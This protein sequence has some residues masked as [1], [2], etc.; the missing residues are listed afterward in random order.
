MSLRDMLSFFKPFSAI[1]LSE[2]NGKICGA[3]VCRKKGSVFVK[4]T[5]TICLEEDKR[6]VKRL[7][8]T[9]AFLATGLE[10][11]DVLTRS[12]HLPS[13]K[14]KDIDAALS[15][16]AE[17]ILPYPVEEAVLTRV[18]VNQ[19]AEDMDLTLLSARKD[20]VK[21]HLENWQ[22][23]KIEPETT[24]CIQGALSRIGILYPV[25]E[26]PLFVLHLGDK[27]STCIL[28]KEGKLIASYTSHI[29]LNALYQA[30]E[31][32]LS[33]LALDEVDFSALSSDQNPRLCEGL[34]HL[35]TALT[36]MIYA[37][38]GFILTGE[39]VR[40]NSFDLTLEQ[41]LHLPL[42]RFEGRAFGIEAR[43]FQQYA[44]PIGLAIEGL[45][46]T[47]ESLN[48]RQQELSYPHPWKRLKIPV[49]L[50][51]SL[52]LLLSAAAYFFGQLYLEHKESQIKQQYVELLSSMGKSY[53]NFEEAFLAKNPARNDKFNGEI[54]NVIQ[55]DKKD[56]FERLEF[57]QKDLQATPDSFPLFANIPK[58]SDVLAWLSTHP[59]VI[60][61]DEEGRIQP[62]LQI[63]NFTYT[64]LKRPV[65]G[66][67]Q[68]KYQVKVEMEFSSPTPTLAREFHDAL[69]AA[70][71]IVDPKGEVKWSANRGKYRTSFYLKDKTSYPGQ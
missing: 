15:F 28:L 40:L 11:T 21:K 59:N 13:V 20:L 60:G 67:K 44:L 41:H 47:K 1:G 71:E 68:E 14:D 5:F 2:A 23:L 55:L 6:N 34:K 66:K 61:K 42:L 32:E 69:I 37:V 65:Q 54:V 16:Q 9:E 50:Y 35:Q 38:E 39:A 62:K 25:K 33:P 18:K 58:V 64:M 70:N 3:E 46:S 22:A 31:K 8:K 29:G 19:D 17:P 24:S 4:S 36:K 12:L 27:S 63:E 48:F 43:D 7:Y 26:K 30:C 52:C 53:E 49:A 56:V 45:P 51:F 57:L 10:G